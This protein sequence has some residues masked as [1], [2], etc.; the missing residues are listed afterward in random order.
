MSAGASFNSKSDSFTIDVID[1]DELRRRDPAF[2]GDVI[3]AA[4]HTESAYA[5]PRRFLV[6][7]AARAQKYGAD[8]RTNANVFHVDVKDGRF[9]RVRLH[10]GLSIE[11]TEVII[12]AGSWSPEFAQKL[13]VTLPMQPGKGY[14]L[15]LTRPDP[16]PRTACVLNER[17]V[18]VTPI[19]DGLRIAGTVEFSGTSS[20]G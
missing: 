6:E 7:L 10:S 3:G 1:G 11:G 16:R 14:H 9:Q 19:E 18:A 15:K 12:A 17:Y 5:D 4:H 8:I 13:G 20:I 2:N